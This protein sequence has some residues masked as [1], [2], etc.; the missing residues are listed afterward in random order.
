MTLRLTLPF[1]LEERLRQ[2]AARQG[3]SGESVALQLL[4]KYLPS[5]GADQ[6]MEAAKNLQELFAAADAVPPTNDDYDLLNALDE[7][8]KGERPLFPP[9]L[10]GISW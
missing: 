3:Q 10:K 9:D 1:D 6:Q 8:R 4:D 5:Q 2:E 7:N